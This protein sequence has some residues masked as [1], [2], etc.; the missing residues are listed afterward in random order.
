MMV[1]V[2]TLKA[3]C[4][5]HLVAAR[6]AIE[7]EIDDLSRQLKESSIQGTNPPSTRSTSTTRSKGKSK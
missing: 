3:R 7:S 2:N 1:R 5:K 6:L 4:I